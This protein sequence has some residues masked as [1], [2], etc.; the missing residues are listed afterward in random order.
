MGNFTEFVILNG[1][2]GG[3]NLGEGVCGG[4]VDGGYVGRCG[5]HGNPCLINWT[6]LQGGA[7]VVSLSSLRGVPINELYSSPVPFLSLN[8]FPLHVDPNI[9]VIA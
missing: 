2:G 4:G 5:I 3:G 7:C 8:N 1:G 9:K 6:M